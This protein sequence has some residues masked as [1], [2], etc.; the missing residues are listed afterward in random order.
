M[1]PIAHDL[2]SRLQS[3]QQY[4]PG[5]KRVIIVSKIVKTEALTL[6]VP[7]TLIVFDH[8]CA[9]FISCA[10]TLSFPAW[11]PIICGSYIEI[12]PFIIF[13][14]SK[15]MNNNIMNVLQAE[16]RCKRPDMEIMNK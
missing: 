13:C 15:N 9:Y 4:I 6:F 5:M 14:N 1:P 7:P 10:L 16:C 8:F 11:N 3:A 2:G 12:L